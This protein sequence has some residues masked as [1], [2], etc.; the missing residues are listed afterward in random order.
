MLGMGLGDFC[1]QIGAV[2]SDIPESEAPSRVAEILPALLATPDLLL[3]EHRAL[4]PQ[5]YGRHDVFIC[6]NDRFSVLAA[7]WPA[8]IFSPIHDHLTWCAFG[9][10]EGTLIETRYLPAHGDKA[11]THATETAV[12]ERHAGD[13]GFLPTDIPDIHCIHNP[14]DKTTIS[15]HVYGGNS[16]KLGPNLEKIYTVE[17]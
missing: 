6:P 12:H 13:A 11:C 17:A 2:V 10:Y 14:T 1:R 7:I 5:G 16:E 9:V 15:I 3:P 4:P 8:G